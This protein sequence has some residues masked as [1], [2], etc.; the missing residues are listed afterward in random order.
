MYSDVRM[1]SARIVQV[2]FLSACD[3]RGPPSVTKT[4]LASCAWQYLFNADVDGSLPIR[5]TPTSWMMRTPGA[6]T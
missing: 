1:A 3:T 6:L 4:F 5:V 2:Q